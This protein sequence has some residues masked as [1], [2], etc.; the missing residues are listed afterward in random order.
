M[1]LPFELHQ[2]EAFVVVG[3]L[4]SI[5]DAADR[6]HI[7]QPAVTRK[8]HKL[9]QALGVQL[10][11]RGNHRLCLTSAGRGFKTDAAY[12]LKEVQIAIAAVRNSTIEQR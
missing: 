1:S 5:Q 2:L 9:E 12:I 7:A 8:I 4:L 6:L 11:V 3:E 10:F